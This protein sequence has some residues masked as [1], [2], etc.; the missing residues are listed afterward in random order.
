MKTNKNRHFI[1]AVIIV[2]AVLLAAAAIVT[3]NH[4]STRYEDLNEADQKVLSELDAY[5]Q[6]SS[7]KDVW[8]GYDL[9]DKTIVAVNGLFGPA[10]LINP[11]QQVSSVFAQKIIMPSNSSL[12]V[13]RISVLAPQVFGLR[14]EFGNFNTIGKTY[15]L[16]GD[17]VYFTKY[18]ARKSLTP[19]YSTNHY[20]TLLTH[21]A[22][23]YYMQTAWPDG[24]RFSQSLSEADIDLI[25]SEYEVLAKIQ[26]E[27]SQNSPSHT[28]LVQLAREYADIMAQRIAANPDYLKAEMAMET[29]EGTA[30]YVSIVASQIAGYDYGV[31][32]FDNVKDVSFSQ[33]IPALRAGN[34]QQSYLADRMPYETGAL[35]CQLL[36]ALNADSWQQ[37]LNSQTKDSPV[38]LYTVITAY[39]AVQ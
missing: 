4:F 32:Y 39:L 9:Q 26:T 25:A 5:F 31:M 30:Q 11:S 7:E 15:H 3:A 12:Q 16:F 10:Y 22:F 17:Q 28:T 23:H 18:T 14:F 33:V 13:Y 37:Q 8:E 35:L 29:A 34:I 21:E 6:T 2:G 24:G 19:P 38:Y 1:R 20:I 27:L 36:N